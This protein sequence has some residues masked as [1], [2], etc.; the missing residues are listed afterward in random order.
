MFRKLLL[1]VLA[2]A[3][4]ACG[5]TRR[6][7]VDSIERMTMTPPACNS[8]T[9]GTVSIPVTTTAGTEMVS[10]STCSAM[11]YLRFVGV[12]AVKV[13]GTEEAR[14]VGIATSRVGYY[15]SRGQLQSLGGVTINGV[16]TEPSARVT[17]SGGG[18]GWSTSGVNTGGTSVNTGPTRVNTSRP[19]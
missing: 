16:N 1:A 14:A 9:V 7:P 17:G 2:L 4:T 18:W 8:Q 10:V 15:D 11:F 3:T 19:R 12:D 6:S 13:L 5:A